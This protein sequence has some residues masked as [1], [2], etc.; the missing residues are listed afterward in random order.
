MALTRD[1]LRVLKPGAALRI[2]VPDAGMLLRSYAG[3]GRDLESYS[4]NRPTRMLAV[5]ETFYW[6]HHVTMYDEPTLLMLFN[7]AGFREPRRCGFGCTQLPLMPDS[8]TR[9]DGT[10]YVEA[11]A[12]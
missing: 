9:R 2:G 7:D 4:P 3:D 6:H 11:V 12:P 8:E 1:C 5:Q 10:L